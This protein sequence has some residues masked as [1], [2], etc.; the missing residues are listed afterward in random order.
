VQDPYD[1]VAYPGQPYKDT[2]PDHLAAM[3][4]LHGLTPAPV[5]RCRV[6]EIGC[7]EGANLIP[8]AYAL[9]GS[10][11]VGF[12]L[13]SQPVAR[14]QERIGELGLQNIRIFSANLLDV[15]SELGEFDYVIAHGL[16]AWIPE[17][18]R[19][20]L[21]AL[22]A[23]VLSPNGVAFISYNA[24][25]GGHIRNMLRDMMM[26]HVRE[27]EDP[28][29]RVQQASAFLEFLA[30]A[31]PSDE[32]YRQQ[33][34]EQLKLMQKRNPWV[35]Y[36][37]ELGSVYLPVH[38]T[39]F[40]EHAGRHGLQYLCESMLP[41]PTDPS[42]RPEMHE[43]LES[44]SGGDLIRQEQI[45]DFIRARKYR[46]TLLCRARCEV[47]RD[48]PVESLKRLKFASQATAKPSGAEGKKVFTLPGGTRMES[49]HAGV[50]ALLEALEAAWP[51][52]LS[53]DELAPRLAEV[54][55][56]LGEAGAATFVRLIV[57][58]MVEPRTWNA[59]FA[60]GIPERPKASAVSRR[61]AGTGV[62]ATTLLHTSMQLSDE[63]G[64]TFLQLLD[65]TR[66]H[67]Q[68]LQA[69]RAAFPDA[70]PGEFK[71]NLDGVLQIFNRAGLLEA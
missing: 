22:C 62:N 58:R 45:L 25:P 43:A 18:V 23:R 11:F 34:K 61:D 50:I 36:H 70:P 67:E 71:T 32:A 37:D 7:S 15:D 1:A 48:F 52:A 39:E 64:R 3:A 49:D 19:D 55:F 51:R 59:P 41:P 57:A 60:E 26:F 6:L 14:G 9:P 54:G 63:V 8:M 29:E 28:T 20:R 13:A 12:D 40:V 16:Y 35:T 31:N 30:E 68:L 33:I 53:Y 2:H 47:R 27:I 5:D 65:G 24:Q 56:M 42:Y 17:L 38:F 44:A 46:E 10:Q 21:M 66:D 4:T 69:M